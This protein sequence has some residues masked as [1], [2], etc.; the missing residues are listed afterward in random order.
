[1]PPTTLL[2]DVSDNVRNV[3]LLSESFFPTR[4][5]FLVPFMAISLQFGV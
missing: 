3:S 1:M 4:F 5:W 2:S